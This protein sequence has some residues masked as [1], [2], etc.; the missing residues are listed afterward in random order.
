M[1]TNIQKASAI[2]H[3]PTLISL[4]DQKKNLLVS[5]EA[6]SA[7][8]EI[9]LARRTESQDKLN[10]LTQEYL[11]ASAAFES[12]IAEVLA[13]NEGNGNHVAAMA[14]NDDAEVVR[15]ADKVKQKGEEITRESPNISRFTTIISESDSAATS[16][17]A[18]LA[19]LDSQIAA[20]IQAVLDAL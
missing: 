18:E 6:E 4:A 7:S 10:T 11:A 15:L 20:Q 1:A 5:I 12:R 17:T 19:L 2:H 16:L 8:K 9:F 14:V 13:A 3:D